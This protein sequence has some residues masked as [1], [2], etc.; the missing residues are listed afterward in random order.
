MLL[1]DPVT[2]L[3]LAG[4]S[5]LSAALTAALG[6]GGG[7]LL[8]AAM[9]GLL[10]A[11]AVI[12]VHG[13]VQLGANAGRAAFTARHVDTGITTWLLAGGILGAAAGTPLLVALPAAALQLTVGLFVLAML[14]MPLPRPSTGSR[15]ATLAFGACAGGL[16]LFVGATG[17][18]V[19]A[20]LQGRALGRVATVAT[21]AACM[22]GLNVFKLLA[23]GFAGF[24][25]QRWL[26]LAALM[27]ACGLAG[28]WLGLRV[29]RG[30]PEERFQHLFRVLLTGLAL[31]AAG[32]GVTALLAG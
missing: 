7:L 15:A 10:P 5:L 29:L 32:R 4:L 30:I 25:W 26:G 11:P 16:S 6:A 27:I 20:F 12:P 24:A 9:A 17:P 31:H 28:T 18:L 3:L 2:T 1:P 13:I 22:T 21:L 8:L 14:W 19:G 23:F